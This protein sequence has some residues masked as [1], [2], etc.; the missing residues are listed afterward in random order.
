[1]LLPDEPPEERAARLARE[2]EAKKRSDLIDEELNRERIAEK[3]GIKPVKILLLGQS[4]SDFQLISSPKVFQAEKASWRAVVHLNVVRSIRLILNAISEVESNPNPAYPAIPSELQKLKMRLQPLALVEK[5]LIR[6]LT[7]GARREIESADP[8]QEVAVNSTAS[9][10]GAFGRL[11]S[12]ARSSIDMQDLPETQESRDARQLLHACSDDMIAL[13]NDPV[14]QEILRLQQLRLEE[15]AGFFLHSIDRVTDT[16]YQ[17]TNDDILKARLKTLG[18]SEHRFTLKGGAMVPQ[19]WIVYDVGGAR[20]LRA[21]WLPYFDQVDALI[22]LVPI[23]CFDQVLAEDETVNRLEDSFLLWK[24]VI[25]TP[26]LKHASLILFLNKCDL[27]KAKLKAGQ[28]FSDYVVSYGDRPND[29]DSASNYL[30]KK[31]VA[32]AKSYSP[33][34]RHFH[35]YFTSVTDMQSTAD[36]LDTGMLCFSALGLI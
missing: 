15:M 7:P 21:A 25:S 33:Q 22:C 6:T 3:K 10:K 23:S 4:E 31:F 17:P 30:R 8:V 11:L 20:S 28:R 24:I 16:S 36:I 9:W 27:L 14:V 32:M 35:T 18:V 19:S 26:L 5:T 2:Q 34:V 12:N 1:M 13:W 29:F